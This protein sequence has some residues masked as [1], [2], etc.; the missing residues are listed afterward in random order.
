[1]PTILD[2]NGQA[3]KILDELYFLDDEF[4][5]EAERIEALNA[6]LNE[7]YGNAEGKI[8]FVLS[9]YLEAQAKTAATDVVYR[10]L[11]KKRNPAKLRKHA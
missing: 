2:L 6:R 1:M 3:R 4:D 8:N 7:I 10:Q 9:L 5:D 11:Q